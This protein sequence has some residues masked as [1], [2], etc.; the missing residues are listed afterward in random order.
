M[1]QQKAQWD[2]SNL[3]Q[4]LDQSSKTK[5]NKWKTKKEKYVNSKMKLNFYLFNCLM[6]YLANYL[7]GKFFP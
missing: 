7:P 2:S 3:T 4:G 6:L 5:V 1:C